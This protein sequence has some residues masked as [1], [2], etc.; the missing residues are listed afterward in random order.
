MIYSPPHYDDPRH[1]SLYDGITGWASHAQQR[2]LTGIAVAGILEWT[3]LVI[4]DWRQGPG[5]GF[6]LTLS[7]VAGWGLLEQ[8]AAI[9]HAALI[10]AAQVLLVILGTI[11]AVM[12]GF[13]WLFWVM[14][15]APVL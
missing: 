8:R 9:P 3:G 4:L 13:A 15:P 12:G 6:L 11:T 1:P 10:T 7:A 5:A 14:G 2:F